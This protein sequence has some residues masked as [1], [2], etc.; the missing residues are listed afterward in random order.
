MPHLPIKTKLFYGAQKVGD[1]GQLEGTQ[2]DG[3]QALTPNSNLA[4]LFFKVI[5][6]L[7]IGLQFEDYINQLC[8]DIQHKYTN[9]QGPDSDTIGLCKASEVIHTV[10]H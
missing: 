10:H 9:L 1:E 3:V 7:A 8:C 2:A 4:A 6:H 5:N